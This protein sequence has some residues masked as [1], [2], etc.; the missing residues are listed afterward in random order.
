MEIGIGADNAFLSR[1]H[2]TKLEL[3]RRNT[4]RPRIE[5]VQR[6]GIPSSADEVDVL[7]LYYDFR[8]LES[9][10]RYV[11][12]IIEISTTV[13]LL[14]LFFLGDFI[15]YQNG[16]VSKSGLC[17]PLTPEFMEV[18]GARSRVPPTRN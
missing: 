7:Q 11:V 3:G 17:S 12:S 13:L 8:K 1:T 9:R 16:H 6:E 18:C 15:S 5:Y 14:P 10:Y 2:H 4:R